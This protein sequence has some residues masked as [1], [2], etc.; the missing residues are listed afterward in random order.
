MRKFKSNEVTSLRTKRLP[1]I[2]PVVAIR[3]K[4]T[5]NQT[6]NGSY[7]F[8]NILVIKYSQ[9]ITYRASVK[10]NF[11]I[12]NMSSDPF[13]YRKDQN[14]FVENLLNTGFTATFAKVLDGV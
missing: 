10:P 5:N 9:E 3:E 11:V 12:L 8:F 2:I 6:D 14:L 1:S 7:E 13:L 4:N